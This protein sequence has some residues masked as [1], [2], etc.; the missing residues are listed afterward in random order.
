MAINIRI[1]NPFT[2]T[3]RVAALVIALFAGAALFTRWDRDRSANSGKA[4]GVE[5]SSPSAWQ[6]FFSPH[7]GC[8]DAIV[9][10]LGK[11][12]QT[13]YVQAYEFTS[14]P[15]VKA[16]VEAGSRGVKVNIILDKSQVSDPH[17]LADFVAQAGIPTLIDSNHQ[18]A[19]NKV[20]V[21][22]DAVVITGSFNFTKAAED[23]N[24]ENL[25][26]I[27]DADLAGRYL[28]NWKEHASHSEP[29]AGHSGRR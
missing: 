28:K 5:S 3:V 17:S 18:L 10:E 7:G 20:M 4:P 25:L 15:I 14:P 19:H 1:Q 12:K 27:H 24:A 26:V 6:V 16:L 22:D 21:I 29:F 13:I 9:T 8:T 11:A 2:Q 23:S